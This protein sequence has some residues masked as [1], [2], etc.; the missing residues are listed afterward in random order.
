[1]LIDA[2]SLAEGSEVVCDL[3]VVGAG[4]SG[5][6]I[7]DRMRN[8]GVKVCLIESRG[9]EPDLRTQNLCRG[10]NAGHRY[11]GLHTC[12]FRMFGGSSNRWGAGAAR[13]SRSTSSSATGFLIAV[14]RLCARSAGGH[15][16]NAYKYRDECERPQTHPHGADHGQSAGCQSACDDP[17]SRGRGASCPS[18]VGDLAG[19]LRRP[20]Q[21]GERAYRVLHVAEAPRL[22]ARRVPTRGTSRQQCR[23]LSWRRVRVRREYRSASTGRS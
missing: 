10:E 3:A 15:C 6:S 8:S 9:F 16:A 20:H 23:C 4:P 7:V 11:F 13:S 22:L 18:R 19:Q 17:I 5:I 12:R 14:G 21:P 2:R 1:M